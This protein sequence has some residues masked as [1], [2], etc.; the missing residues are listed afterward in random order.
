MSFS[1]PQAFFLLPLLLIAAVPGIF[2][3]NRRGLGFSSNLLFKG[4]APSA[5]QRWEAV[6]K[7]SVFAGIVLLI[8][9]LAGP[10]QPLG[11]EHKETKGIAM[12][13]VMDRSSSM[14]AEIESKGQFIR[15]MDVTKN[16]FRDF[17]FGNGKELP[18]RENDMIGLITFARYADTLAPLSTN[19]EILRDFLDSIDTVTVQQE[20]GTSIGDAIALAAA[21]LSVVDEKNSENA[22]ANGFIIKSRIIILLTDGENNAGERSPKEAAEFA[23]SQGVKVYTIGFAGQ[24]YRTMQGMFGSQRVPYG[25]AVDEETLKAIA[26]MTGGEYFPVESPSDLENVYR[27]IDSLET[28]EVL[29][30]E[31]PRY[32]ELFYLPAAAGLILILAGF[33][34]GQF[35]FRRYP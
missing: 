5:R 15:R 27:T 21:R 9:A 34:A 18:G 25:S 26:D 17:V 12:Q 29:S 32:K 7:A 30:V 6:S 28:S 20:D 35:V 22:G 23:R 2:A 10:R 11:E 31:N 13:L 1:T 16:T 8:A 19:H 24:A 4:I 3:R 33:L 14:N